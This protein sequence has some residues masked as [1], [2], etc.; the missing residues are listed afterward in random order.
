MIRKHIQTSLSKKLQ[1]VR[2]QQLMNEF[3]KP[4]GSATAHLVKRMKDGCCCGA[5]GWRSNHRGGQHTTS[6]THHDCITALH[7]ESSGSA[8]VQ[9]TAGRRQGA[10]RTLLGVVRLTSL[11]KIVAGGLDGYVSQKEL[12]DKTG[13]DV[14][15]HRFDGQRVWQALLAIYTECFHAKNSQN[16]GNNGWKETEHKKLLFL[17]TYTTSS[18]PPV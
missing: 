12:F 5:G 11:T 16:G 18:K 8:L 6:T 7:V 17:I 13:F 10:Q 15:Q 2:C 9:W 14:H 3:Q 4:P 1:L